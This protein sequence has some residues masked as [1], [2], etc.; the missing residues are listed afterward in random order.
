MFFSFKT[1]AIRD[2]LCVL[3]DESVEK[4]KNNDA[5]LEVTVDGTVSLGGKM[6]QN[7]RKERRNDDMQEL[8]Q[9]VH[10][11]RVKHMDSEAG[12]VVVLV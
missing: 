8:G 10:C 11:R 6:G 4:G 7:P 3:G 1:G 9:A 2:Y 12:K 5:G